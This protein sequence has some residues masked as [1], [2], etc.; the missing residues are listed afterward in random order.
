M[1]RLFDTLTGKKQELKT[2]EPEKVGIY[3]CGPTVYDYSHL[4]HARVYVVFDTVV[5]Y[6]RC[7]GHDVTY[8]RNYTDVDDKIIGRAAE[9]GRD[10][11][12]LAAEFITAFG[13]DM[14]RLNVLP[15]DAEPKVS[16]HIPEIV[17]A[18]ERIGRAGLAY[19]RKG[20]VYFAVRRH[21]TYGK[22]S[23]RNLDDLR[24]GARVEVDADKEDPLDFALW[25]AAKPGEPHWPSPWGEGRP[26]W[27]IECSAMSTKYLG[28]EFD[29]HGGGMDL[30]FP[31][32]EN[33]I[34]QSEA[35]YAS[36]FARYWMHNG[37]VNLNAEKMA[38]STGNFFTLRELFNHAE[39]E[40]IRLFLQSV[41]YRHPINFKV[42]ADPEGG[43]RF[44]DLVEAEHRLDYFYETLCKIEDVLGPMQPPGDGEVLEELD[45][46][47]DGFVAAMDDDF[48]TAAALAPVSELFK[49]ANRLLEDPKAA[50]KRRQF[51]WRIREELQA[52]GGVLGLW[53]E[54]PAEYLCRRLEAL[55]RCRGVDPAWVETQIAAR[56]VARQDK[57]FAAADAIRDTLVDK[58]VELMDSPQGTRWKFS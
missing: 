27:H 52:I 24:S 16:D 30:V 22:L 49:L 45:A 33:E 56:A 40:A 43:A 14:D 32:H 3:V 55:A 2:H 37:F 47:W 20:T 26:G 41:Q 23:K 1:L 4:G 25:K 15:A 9:Q 39:P 58:G 42:D 51:L 44:P 54:S 11:V 21:A 7:R 28:A 5:R 34:A 18:I 19:E 53:Q 38:K 36:G 35:A 6:L 12:E 57:D 8:V 29:I 50:P 31:H 17:D 10:P 46:A 13:Q 48:N